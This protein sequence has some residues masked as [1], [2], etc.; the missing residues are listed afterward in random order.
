MQL[1]YP[2]LLIVFIFWVGVALF[3]EKLE[4][5]LERFFTGKL[6]VVFKPVL[7][8]IESVLLIGTALVVI[9]LLLSVSH[10]WPFTFGI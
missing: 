4:M 3:M 8:M 7:W 9:I 10:S 5:C 6:K 1:V 2:L